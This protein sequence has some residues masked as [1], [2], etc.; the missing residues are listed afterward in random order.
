MIMTI[1]KNAVDMFKNIAN[2]LGAGYKESRYLYLRECKE[3]S[4]VD[5]KKGEYQSSVTAEFD[6]T[7]WFV[8]FIKDCELDDSIDTASEKITKMIENGDL[9]CYIANN[10][11]V[12]MAAQTR[13]VKGGRCVGMVYTPPE[14]RGMGYSIACMKHLTQEILD[15]GNDVAF[16]YS[17]KYNP[18]SNHVY[19]KLGYE[20]TDDFMEYSRI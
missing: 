13:K 10:N 11:I 1:Y 18:I 14:N 7:N 17:D 19:E 20:K 12:T 4:N 3:V 2:N 8:G 15:S 5:I 9:V 16:L 6:F